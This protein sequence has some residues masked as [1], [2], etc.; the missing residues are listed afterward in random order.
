MHCLDLGVCQHICGSTIHMLVFDA[1]IPGRLDQR[2]ATVWQHLCNAY[3]ARG[4]PQGERLQHAAFL[5]IFEK[6]RSWR[7]TKYPELHSKAAICRHCVPALKAVVGS[8][9]QGCAAFHHVREVLGNL[10]KFYDVLTFNG[11]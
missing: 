9:T 8:V 2:L 10:A 11:M 4:T 1:E 6:N 7:P 3:D 5:N